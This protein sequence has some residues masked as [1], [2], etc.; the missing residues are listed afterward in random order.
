MQSKNLA[1]MIHEVNEDTGDPVLNE[2]D[3][4]GTNYV[5]KDGD[6]S[7]CLAKLRY[8]IT[9]EL[10]IYNDEKPKQLQTDNG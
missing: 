4:N 8:T 9:I 2:E 3:G 6:A 1:W 7:R 10:S 5:A